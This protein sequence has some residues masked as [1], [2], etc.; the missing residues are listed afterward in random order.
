MR[1][2]LE[3]LVPGDHIYW[4]WVGGMFR[5]LAREAATTVAIEAKL[6]GVV[7]T[8]MQAPIPPHRVAENY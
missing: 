7:Q 2:L 1:R 3:S 5:K 4:R 8:A 6:R